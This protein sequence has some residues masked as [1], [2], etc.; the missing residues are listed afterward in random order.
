ME[1][2]EP[3]SWAQNWLRGLGAQQVTG[4]EIADHV[5]RVRGGRRG[6]RTGDEVF[7]QSRVAR[8][9]LTTQSTADN[10][11]RRLG[12]RAERVGVGGTGSLNTNKGEEEGEDNGEDDI[13]QVHV[14][15]ER[16][17]Q[18]GKDD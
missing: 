16:A 13:A 14:E 18:A 15:L 3:N 10:E 12:H 17:N 4:L 6:N 1:K 2:N 7:Q 8:L 5:D 11:L 9:T